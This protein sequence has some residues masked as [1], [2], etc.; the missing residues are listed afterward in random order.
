MPSPT[1]TAQTTPLTTVARRAQTQTNVRISLDIGYHTCTCYDGQHVTSLRSVYAKLPIGQKA[2][3]LPETHIIQFAGDR[4]LVGSGALTQ[5]N[6]LPF[7]NED[8]LSPHILKMALYA[9]A[10]SGK[11]DLVISHYSADDS[12]ERLTNILSGTHTY[13]LNGERKDLDIRRV[14]VLDEGKGSWLIAQ[15][16]GLI[17]ST[18]YSALIDLGCDTF[19]A[20]F[21]AA[22][23]TR[24]EHQAYPQQGAKS[25]A[26]AIASDARLIAAVAAS[27]NRSKPQVAR[28]LDG[29]AHGHYYAHTSATWSEYFAEYR[30]SWFKGIFGAVKTDFAHLLPDTK[31]FIVTGGGAHLVADK[32]TDAAAFIVLDK[33]EIANAVG[34]YYAQ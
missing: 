27:A 20:S 9:L 19:I 16:K 25:L 1:L 22:D 15:Q 14:T 5:R 28:I 3:S 29:F 7:A 31:R 26:T 24:I 32:L 4:Y 30:D 12:A 2:P 6:Y 11:V 17:P 13:T 10:G 18:G 8:K 21:Y 23:G 34:A 33:P